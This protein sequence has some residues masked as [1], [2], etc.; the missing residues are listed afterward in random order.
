MFFQ[1][2]YPFIVLMVLLNNQ[3]PAQDHARIYGVVGKNMMGFG[4]GIYFTAVTEKKLNMVTGIE[5][6]FFAFDAET[7][8]F[9]PGRRETF[10]NFH[11]HEHFISPLLHGRI[12]IET[13]MFFDIGVNLNIGISGRRK[14]IKYENPRMPT[15]PYDPYQEIDDHKFPGYWL[16]PILRIGGEIPAGKYK[17]I[18]CTETRLFWIEE[19]LNPTVGLSAGWVWK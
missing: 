11:L 3:L 4:T 8:E 17:I 18:L 16:S 7:L 1:R 5:Y 14:T 9:D 19:K 13:N 2:L 12:R 15:G 10:Y 6:G